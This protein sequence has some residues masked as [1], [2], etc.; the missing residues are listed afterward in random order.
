MNIDIE[1]RRCSSALGY[2]TSGRFDLLTI[3]G[4][5]K[6]EILLSIT[7]VAFGQTEDYHPTEVGGFTMIYSGPHDRVDKIELQGGG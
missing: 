3:D 7:I 4:R 1:A 6:G 5:Q 2:V